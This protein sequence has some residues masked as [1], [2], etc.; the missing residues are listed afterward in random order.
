MADERIN[1]RWSEPFWVN[2]K[3]LTPEQLR[4][5]EER[6]EAMR[7]YYR[8]GGPRDCIRHGL[9]PEGY[10]G[11]APLPEGLKPHPT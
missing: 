6:R 8:T 9:F 3:E 4:V 7:R 1:S 10:E 5:V 11:K 2:P